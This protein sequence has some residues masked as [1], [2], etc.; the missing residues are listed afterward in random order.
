MDIETLLKLALHPSKRSVA[1]VISEIRTSSALSLPCLHQSHLFMVCVEHK[2]MTPNPPMQC[3]DISQRLNGL[4]FRGTLQAKLSFQL[5]YPLF[6]AL[7]RQ[8]RLIIFI[9][10]QAHK[11]A[12]FDGFRLLEFITLCRPLSNRFATEF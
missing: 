12:I 5:T 6:D 4:Y 7:I 10:R 1:L 2:A 8:V 11:L 9:Q 3:S